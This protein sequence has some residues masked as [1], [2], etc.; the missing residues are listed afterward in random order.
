MSAPD[1]RCTAT[2]RE[3]GCAPVPAGDGTPPEPCRARP[4]R[5]WCGRARWCGR[6]GAV[7]PGRGGGTVVAAC[8]REQ[9]DPAGVDEA[10]LGERTAVRLRFAF[11][12]AEQLVP[13]LTV[14]EEPGGDR[15]Q[16]IAG[17]HAVNPGPGRGSIAAVRGLRRRGR[18]AGA[19]AG[20]G[21][22][23]VSGPAA[24]VLA[25]SAVCRGGEGRRAACGTCSE[26]S[27]VA[28][29]R[30]AATAW[31]GPMTGS[32]G[33]GWPAAVAAASISTAAAVSAHSSQTTQASPL[34]MAPSLSGLTRNAC[35][36][37]PVGRWRGSGQPV[38]RASKYGG[39]VSTNAIAA[40]AAAARPRRRRRPGGRVTAVP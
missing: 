23:G 10:R 40:S 21:R 4:G 29:M 1:G 31:T 35:S 38:K 30:V 24:V 8:W 9:Q 5:R 39:P 22:P 26:V 12:E 6:P 32:R 13:A 27:T 25:V 16:V 19:A 15:P 7:V 28:L 36:C 11:V 2:G 20:A 18:G 17:H 33:A 3:C 37:V 34:M 14:A